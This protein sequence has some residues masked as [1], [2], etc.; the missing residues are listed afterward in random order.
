MRIDKFDGTEYA[1]LSNFYEH[2]FVWMHI[3]Y[4]TAEHA[5]QTAKTLDIHERAKI[6]TAKTPAEA[7]RLGRKCSMRADWDS[8]KIYIMD[9]ILEAKFRDPDLRAKLLETKNAILIEGN[10]WHDNYWGDCYCSNCKDIH[11]KNH[12]GRALMNLR[13]ELQLEK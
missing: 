6:R 4:P 8:T 2:R 5:F 1:F 7:K 3:H 12:L 11:G 9:M 13:N 10:Q